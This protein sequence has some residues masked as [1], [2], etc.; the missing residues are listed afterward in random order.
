MKIRNLTIQGFR[1][2]NEERTI[3]FHDRLTLIYASNSYGKTSISEALEWLLYGVTSKV[4][5]ADS[6]EEYRG[7]YRNVHLSESLTPFVRATFVH[8][9]NESEVRGELAEDDT[10]GRFVQGQEAG[11]W[12]LP[13]GLAEV[14]RPFVLQHAVKHLLLAK[15]DE[16]FQAFARLL[17]L[18]ELEHIQRKVVALCTKPDTCVPTEVNQLLT[19]VSTLESR[20]AGQ[21]SLAT[22]EKAFKKGKDSLSE[23]Y[24]LIISE[25]RRRVPSGTEEKSILPQL[26]KVR[27]ESVGKIFG[28]RITLKEYS[29]DEKQANAEDEEFFLDFVT[30]GFAEKYSAL[31][32]LATIQYILDRAQFFGLGVRLLGQAPAKCPFCGQSIDDVLLEH[33]HNEHQG[34]TTERAR[35]E[36]LEEQRTDVKRSLQRLK[37]R[38]RDYRN[39]QTAK[40]TQLL[41]SMS[42]LDELRTILVPEQQVHFNAVGSAISEL[43]T[44]KKTLEACCTRVLEVLDKIETS[45]DESKENEALVT[46]LREALPEYIAHAHSY[47][48]SVSAKV[49]AMSDADQILKRELDKLAGT[50]DISILVDLLEHWH[51]VKKKFEVEMILE[52]LKDLRRVVDQYVAGR[53]LKA[54]SEELTSEVTEWY[55]LIKTIGDPDV[56][57]GGFDIARTKGG[58]PRARRVQIK[59]KSY[60]KEL[61]SAVSSLSESK[62]NALGLCVSIATNLKGESLFDFLVIDDPIQSWDAE[63]EIQFIDVIRKLIERGKQVILLSHNRKWIDSVRTG[64]RS[65]NGRFYEITG[66]TKAGPHI[67]E[68]SWVNWEA[69]LDEVNAILQDPASTSVRLQQAEEEIRIVVAELTA[70]L[71]LGKKGVHASP[72]RLNSRAVRSMLVK[73]GV[74]VGLVDRITQTFETTNVA[75]HASKGHATH[76]QRIQRYHSWVHELAQLLSQKN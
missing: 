11:S 1:G 9:G 18:E 41:E 19:N 58:E 66:Y 23:T 5:K 35:S 34:L 20:L 36:T 14:P 8:N 28:G 57:F 45:I 22:I 4:E 69:R 52:G 65:S 46:T 37:T 21:P 48:Q 64:C 7:S 76:R 68:L 44:A 70:E 26:L 72:H 47:I 49:S 50:E 73:C 24:D 61:V 2:F 31:G 42:S 6:K 74:E 12:L 51:D 54:I 15:P 39:R 55:G 40:A 75:H 32:A 67:K 62:L 56:H 60:G 33:I 17:R 59:A 38:L 53:V 71:Y 27:E 25:C 3:D 29:Q 10:I 30:E 63:H 43:T 13:Q 16:R